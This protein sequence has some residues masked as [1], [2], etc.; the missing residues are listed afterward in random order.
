MNLQHTVRR[1][2]V[3]VF[4]V[5]FVLGSPMAFAQTNK[6]SESKVVK[7]AT[8]QDVITPVDHKTLKFSTGTE[9][10]SAEMRE[11]IKFKV[12]GVDDIRMEDK[13]QSFDS[14]PEQAETFKTY[15]GYPKHQAYIGLSPLSVSSKWSYTK[16]FNYDATSL[17]IE[18]GY[19]FVATPLITFELNWFRYEVDVAATSGASVSPYTILESK[20]TVDN[21]KTSTSYCFIAGSSFFHRI[22]PGLTIGKESY[23]VLELISNTALK[24]SNVDDIVVGLSLGYQAPLTDSLNLQ[25]LLGYN[26]GTGVGNSGT[27]TSEKNS[28]LYFRLGANY[29]LFAHSD[30]NVL[31][32]YAS[33]NAELVGKYAGV[34]RTW[35]SEITTIA[36]KVIYIFTF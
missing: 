16:D 28:N 5:V 24:M 35:D 31:F 12:P 7:T 8:H 4:L 29:N 6:S 1:S 10:G 17:G 14:V 15:V 18:L 27:L 22:C 20:T 26:I 9:A 30:I 11:S 3:L 25:S 34:T 21:F 19:K 2:S 32:E 36:G 23:P 13:P 33:R